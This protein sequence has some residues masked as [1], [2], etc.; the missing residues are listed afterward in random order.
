MEKS[1]VQN[2]K[3][4]QLALKTKKEIDSL[5]KKL[6]KSD[7]EKKKIETKLKE[8]NSKASN[9]TSSFQAEYDR[10]QVILIYFIMINSNAQP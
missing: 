4:K 10:L 2:K 8:I 7:E 3:L 1:E 9:A 6:E 5:K